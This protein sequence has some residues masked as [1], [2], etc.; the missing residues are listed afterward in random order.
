M[1]ISEQIPGRNHSVR[2]TEE[3]IDGLHVTYI[4]AVE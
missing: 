1:N 4:P 3:I 2:N